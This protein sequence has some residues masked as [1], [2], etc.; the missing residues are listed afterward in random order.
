MSRCA[1]P[2]AGLKGNRCTEDERLL[3]AIREANPT[4]SKLLYIVDFRPYK[5]AVGNKIMGKGSENTDHYKNIKISYMNIDNIHAVRDSHE[6]IAALINDAS[7][8]D[9]TFYSRLEETQWLF[10]IRNILAAAVKMVTIFEEEGASILCHCSDGWDRTSQLCSLVELLVDPYYRT[11]KGFA[12]LIEAEWLSFGHKFAERCGHADGRHGHTQ[13]APVFVQWLDAVW[14]VMRQ[15]PQAFEFSEEFLVSIAEHVYSCRFGTFLFETEG[16]RERHGLERHTAS[17]WTMLCAQE[18][19]H[20]ARLVNPCYKP[21]AHQVILPTAHMKKLVVWERY[22]MPYD[23]GCGSWSVARD[24]WELRARLSALHQAAAAA[25]V[26]VSKFAL[27]ASLPTPSPSASP[28]PS[29]PATPSSSSSASAA[30]AA[31]LAQESE[32]AKALMAF[33]IDDEEKDA[34]DDEV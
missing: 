33:L 22:F 20:V 9:D 6:K 30:A 26:D 24:V 7:Q 5:A 3:A 28:C 19:E 12:I 18:G 27:D 10:H 29:V 25:G 4:N 34:D 1:Q 2:L 31:A 8:S 32:R 15:F 13:R 23:Q 17:L 21:N 11:R 14:Q 16:E